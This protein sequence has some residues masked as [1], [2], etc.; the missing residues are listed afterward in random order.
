MPNKVNIVW[1]ATQ[2]DTFVNCPMFFDYRHNKN[3]TPPIKAKPL[4]QGG[5]MHLG[6]EA[7]YKGLQE[8]LKFETSLD[9]GLMAIRVGL[10]DSDLSSEQG[11]R[12]LEVFEEYC[13]RWRIEDQ[14]WVINAVEQAF[15][16]ELY[17]DDLIRI[18]WIGKIDLLWSN[19]QY[20]NLPVDHK[21]YERDFP[22][23]RLAN[24]FT[25]YAVATNS[26]FLHVNRIGFQTSIKPEIKHKRVSLSYDPIFKEQW[27]RNVIKWSYIYYDC[28][29]E[30]SWPMNNTSCFK[31]NRLCEFHS[32]CETTGDQNKIHK[33][34]TQFITG[35][36]WDVSKALQKK[37]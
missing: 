22:L 11:N 7:Y 13:Y 28:N 15:M 17:E 29:A 4:D 33:L 19:H 21:T 35:E 27:K 10:T 1:D 30:G 31:F 18:I 14:G 37:G 9:K 6:C 3:K 34:N 20:E 2:F 36:P 32:I 5:I 26:N 25:G 8:N 24:Q 23:S 12:C 16:F